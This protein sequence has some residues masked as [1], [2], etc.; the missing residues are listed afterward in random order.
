MP[1]ALSNNL[2]QT[3][4]HELHYPQ[5]GTKRHMANSPPIKGRLF[6]YARVSTADQKLDMQIE[7]LEKAGVAR[8]DIYVETVSGASRRRPA[9]EKCLKALRRGDTLYVWKVDRIGRKNVQVLSR[10][11]DLKSRGIEFK[12]LTEPIDFLTP[13]GEVMV[14]ISAAMA[15]YE[16]RLT[17]ERTAHGIATHKAAGKPYGRKTEFELEKA[18]KHLRKHKNVSAAAK[19]VGVTRQTLWYHVQK[20]KTLM[21]LLKRRAK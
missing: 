16:R 9:L 11:D 19:H 20:D 4:R 15:Q 14:A 3:I 13:I 8:A 7:A 17:S 10:L 5:H 12:S 21:A 1:L 6:G 18:L 2:C